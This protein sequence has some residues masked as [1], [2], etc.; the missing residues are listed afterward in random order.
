M[1]DSRLEQLLWLP[2]LMERVREHLAELERAEPDRS[3]AL[4]QELA[5][6]DSNIKGWSQSLADPDLPVELRQAIQQQWK[7]ALDRQQQI[8]QH[9]REQAVMCSRAEE[10]LDHDEV[11]TRLEKLAEVLAEHNPTLGNLELSFHI[12]RIDCHPDGRVEMR[13]CQLGALTGAYEL[14]AESGGA[15]VDDAAAAP[16]RGTTATGPRRRTRLRL[17]YVDVERSQLQAAADF[18]ADPYRFSDLG[19][20]WFWTDTFQVPTKSPS[21]AEE[22]AE[23]VQRRYNELKAAKGKKPS[24]NVLAAEF[25]KSRPTISAA[26]KIAENGGPLRDPRCKDPGAPTID[27]KALAAEFARLEQEEGLQRAVIAKR[28]GVHRNT[29]ARVLNDW[30]KSQGIEPQDARKSRWHKKAE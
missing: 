4:Q 24:L 10:V 19:D 14:V 5:Q 16:G 20:E 13:T 30:Y 25:G 11:W 3:A 1:E 26:L 12:D 28:H 7:D 2:E 6:L 23:A 8:Q 27:A 21:W 29:V 22:H 18:V 15:P 9:I 17:N